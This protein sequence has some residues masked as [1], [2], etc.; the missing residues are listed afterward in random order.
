MSSLHARFHPHTQSA[1]FWVVKLACI[2][3]PT[4]TS[5][6]PLCSRAPLSDRKTWTQTH[7]VHQE[8]R[9]SM[10]SF[11]WKQKVSC[12][13]VCVLS[14]VHLCLPSLLIWRKARVVVH[15]F[16]NL[17]SLAGEASL[18]RNKFYFCLPQSPTSLKYHATLPD[19]SC[20]NVGI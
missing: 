9:A 8:K 1:C 7:W 6:L 20:A 10:P 3:G 18:L 11:P 14:G 19:M 13:G 5:P 4:P 16:L 17:V 12:L 2:W 15:N